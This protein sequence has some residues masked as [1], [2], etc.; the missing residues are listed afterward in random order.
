MLAWGCAAEEGGG[1]GPTSG[2]EASSTAPAGDS[3]ESTSASAEETSSSEG[4]GEVSSG[5]PDPSESSGGG[6]TSA[7][8]TG[9]GGGDTTGEVA[10]DPEFMWVADFLRS[11][12]VRCHSTNVNGNLLLP[13][14][15]LTNE[16]VRVAL[17]DVVATTGLL[18]VEP[19]DR[20]SSQ[21]WLQITNEF[22]A[23]FPVEETDRFGAW[24]DAGAAYYAE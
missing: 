1:M 16:E 2:T 15:D 20:E 12:C 24:I 8:D 6:S 11:N 7:A 3:G 10:F 22:G 9:E 17:D 14:V 13:D 21:T 4:G 19:F 23:I 18:L 5:A